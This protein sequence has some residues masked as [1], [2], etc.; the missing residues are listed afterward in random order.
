MLAKLNTQMQTLYQLIEKKCEQSHNDKRQTRMLLNTEKLP[1]YINAALHHFRKCLDK[2]FNFVTE[3]RRHLSPP[4]DFE[5]HILN[6]ILLMYNQL[7]SSKKGAN[8]AADCDPVFFE[9]LTNPIASSVMLAALRDNTQ[10]I[11]AKNLECSCILFK[12]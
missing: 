5:G 2:P 4:Q 6:F 12:I 1:I 11:S 9:R 10:G 3:A 7:E 8:K